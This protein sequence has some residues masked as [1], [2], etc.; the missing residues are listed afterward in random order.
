M[1]IGN[2]LDFDKTEA[3]AE[4]QTMLMPKPEDFND[5]QG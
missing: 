3:I 4:L 1:Y 5:Q 2:I